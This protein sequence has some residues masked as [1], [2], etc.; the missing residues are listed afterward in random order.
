MT[1]AR[2][3]SSKSVDGI[4]TIRPDR[5]IAEAVAE[6]AARGI[7]ALIVSSDGKAP[8][9]IL[10]ERDV[11]R[12]LARE[13]G[14]VLE[15]RASDLM[16]APIQT[17]SPAEAA[18]ETLQRMTVGRFRHMPVVEDGALV[19]VISIGD[20]VKMRLSEVK[21]ERDAMEAMIAGHG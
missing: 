12:A 19:G 16:T 15:R 8:E 10:S 3:L 4:H 13:G 6:L 18:E 2:V 11:V 21:S 14:A 7:G 17:A 20:V 9:G 5:T 1:V